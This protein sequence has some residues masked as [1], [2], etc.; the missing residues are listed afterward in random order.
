MP[1]TFLE[2]LLSGLSH[3]AV[4][5]DHLAFLVT[6]GVVAALI[7]AGFSLIAAF[8]T[9]AAVGAWTHGVNF[10]FPLAEQLV[11]ASVVVAGLLVA[12]GLGARQIIWLPIGAIAGLLHGY[13]F[14]EEILG[15]D[16]PVIAAYLIGVV[17][18]C[19]VITVAVMQFASQALA[20]SD[21]RSL[22]LRI[23]GALVGILGV[24]LLVRLI[25]N[26]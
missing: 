26:G 25:M 16:G 15:A 13:A 17:I 12:L 4:G 18:V 2:G 9:A 6:L 5:L 7:P 3:P 14:G 19:S 22:P 11:A 20:L 10:D 1:T 8:I 24:V 23:A 21:A